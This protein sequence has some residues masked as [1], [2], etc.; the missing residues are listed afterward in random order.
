MLTH[1]SEELESGMLTSGS[2][3]VDS[4]GGILP[5]SMHP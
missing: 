3:E 4:Q 2:E 1:G 5:M